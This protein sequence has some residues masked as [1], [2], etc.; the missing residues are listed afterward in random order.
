MEQGTARCQKQRVQRQR[1]GVKATRSRFVHTPF[2]HATLER[3]TQHG[4]AHSGVML[5]AE[6]PYGL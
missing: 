2:V 4:A 3:E 5:L 1:L 6:S